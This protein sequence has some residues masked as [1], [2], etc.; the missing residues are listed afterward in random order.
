LVSGLTPSIF[1]SI[2]RSN[3]KPGVEITL[4]QLKVKIEN[5]NPETLN[6]E[7][8]TNLN[9]THSLSRFQ[10]NS[11]QSFLIFWTRIIISF[12]T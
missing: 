10:I 3:E 9:I 12:V 4:I 11:M 6:F 8:E 7:P 5:E 2:Q 1:N